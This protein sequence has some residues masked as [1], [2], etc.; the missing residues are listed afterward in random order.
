MTGPQVAFQINA[1]CVLFIS[2]LAIT[3]KIA[4]HSLTITCSSELAGE[5]GGGRSAD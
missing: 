4:I 2:P 3:V 1:Y 5:G